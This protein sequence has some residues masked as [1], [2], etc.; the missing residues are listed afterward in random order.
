MKKYSNELSVGIFA[1][2]GLLCLAYLTLTLGNLDFLGRSGYNLH[3]NFSSVSGLR[4]GASVEVGGVTVGK[5]TS[6]DLVN[7]QGMYMAQVTM[8]ISQENLEIYDDA[9]L[10]VKTSGI[11]GDK[12]LELKPGGGSPTRLQDGDE[13]E[14]TTSTVDIETLISN[15]VFS[16]GGEGE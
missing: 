9:M 3:A 16:S 13:I 1:F 15:F 8:N 10:S 12:Y 4:T 11:I 7:N 5:V 2:L 6:I 14:E